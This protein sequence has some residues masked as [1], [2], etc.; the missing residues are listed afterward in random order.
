M[1]QGSIDSFQGTLLVGAGIFFQYR[2]HKF[3]TSRNVIVPGS[4]PSNS[5]PTVWYVQLFL[6]ENCSSFLIRHLDKMSQT[7]TL[8]P[9]QNTVL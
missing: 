2:H 8:L 4:P 7:M 9:S 3:S 5:L 6:R 1:T